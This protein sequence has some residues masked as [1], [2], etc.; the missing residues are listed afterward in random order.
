MPSRRADPRRVKLH[1]SYT[2]PELAAC[3]GVHK[4]TVREWQRAGLK[5]LD[6]NRPMLFQGTTV[7]AFLVKRNASRKHP[8]KPGTLFCFRCREPRPPALGMLDYQASTARSGNLKAMCGVCGAMMHRRIRLIDLP[9][10]MPGMDVQ[11]TQA[12]PRLKGS[13]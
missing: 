2:V 10:K 6:T 5:P 13:P 8:C 4:N 7:R 1:R 3:F 9:S 12:P 11:I